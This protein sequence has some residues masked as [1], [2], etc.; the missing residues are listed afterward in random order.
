MSE[1]NASKLLKDIKVLISAHDRLLAAKQRLRQEYPEQHE[2]VCESPAFAAWLYFRGHET[3]QQ[4]YKFVKEAWDS[5]EGDKSQ[6]WVWQT[7]D[8]TEPLPQAD[9]LLDRIDMCM[10]LIAQKTLTKKPV[11]S[12]RDHGWHPSQH[13]RRILA[14]AQAANDIT[15]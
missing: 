8:Q 15:A 3:E 2:Q 12:V 6:L 10:G 14:F 4:V 9:H 1:A 7:P 11:E 5:F 13:L